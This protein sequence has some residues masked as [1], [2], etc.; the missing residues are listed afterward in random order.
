M[1]RAIT[2]TGTTTATMMI[3]VVVDIEPLEDAPSTLSSG[4]GE[5]NNGTD[6]VAPLGVSE[7]DEPSVDDG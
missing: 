2:S 7:S 3:T 6:D 1:A 4:G 5:G